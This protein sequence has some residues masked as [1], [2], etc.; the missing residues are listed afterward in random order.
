MRL[1]PPPDG[2]TLQI[3]IQVKTTPPAK[4]HL[5]QQLVDHHKVVADR[6]LLQL[7]KVVLEDVDEAVEEHLG[8][9][10]WSHGFRMVLH[11]GVTT[12]ACIGVRDGAA[13]T[14]RRCTP[15]SS[16]PE[17]RPAAFRPIKCPQPRAP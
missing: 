17:E 12:C 5:V 14:I 10:V 1:L 9:G 16:S 13:S 15:E 6:L 2:S 3:K 8:G 4:A 11:C 7:L